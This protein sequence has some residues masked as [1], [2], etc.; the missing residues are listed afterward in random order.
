MS[1]IAQSELLRYAQQAPLRESASTLKVAKAFGRKTVFLSHSH[2]DAEL[3][4]GLKNRLR[5]QDV[6]VYIDWEDNSMPDKPN[7]ETAKKVKEKIVEC[8]LFLFLATQ[9]S[10]SSRW[11]PWEIGFADGKKA[12]DE[13]A[14]V[15][16]RDEQ[17]RYYGN[18]Y[19]QLYRRLIITDNMK[20]MGVFKPGEDK[21]NLFG[22]YL[23]YL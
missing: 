3:A 4:K 11:C 17:G 9:N 13:I 15:P 18:E 10:A 19:L 2:K 6:D 21:G 16:T 12:Y 5:E 22:K 23:T 7:G 14:I 1:I 20:K 8:H